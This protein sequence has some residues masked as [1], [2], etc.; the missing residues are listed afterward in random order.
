MGNFN[1][2]VF[3]ALCVKVGGAIRVLPKNIQG[4]HNR[5][6]QFKKL[7]RNIIRI[8]RTPSAAANVLVSPVLP[9][10][11][12]SCL[13]RGLCASFQDIISAGKGFLCA[14]F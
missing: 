2:L 10:V 7:T 14:P 8:K 5:L 1:M 3:R 9:A 4:I 13:L 11:R 12:F 6:V